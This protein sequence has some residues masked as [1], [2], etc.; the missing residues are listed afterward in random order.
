[1]Y[2]ADGQRLMV[3][4][5]SGS[6]LLLTKGLVALAA[7]PSAR[8]DEMQMAMSP[9]GKRVLLAGSEGFDVWTLGDGSQSQI[10]WVGGITTDA[11]V[12]A[13]APDDHLLATAN[14]Q[15]HLSLWSADERAG[16]KRIPT[17][18]LRIPGTPVALAVSS[19]GVLASVLRSGSVH[20]MKLPVVA[21]QHMLQLGQPPAPTEPA[22]VA[23]PREGQER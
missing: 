21:V 17:P 4:Q 1:M 19:R 10:R 12:F 20:L 13:F 8:S 22:V 11:P 3:A 14:H 18:P 15:G 16:L 6:L 9:D 7:V 2:S 23:R 5:E